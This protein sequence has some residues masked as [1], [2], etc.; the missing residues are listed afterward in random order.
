[1][2]NP[3]KISLKESADEQVLDICTDAI[4]QDYTINCTATVETA[5]PAGS[6]SEKALEGLN[7][8]ALSIAQRAPKRGWKVTGSQISSE[9]GRYHLRVT[10]TQK[11]DPLTIRKFVHQEV[12]TAL[13]EAVKDIT[14]DPS[15]CFFSDNTARIQAFDSDLS[16][17][18]NIYDAL[19]DPIKNA[20]WTIIEAHIDMAQ[21]DNG[22]G[23]LHALYITAVY[24]Q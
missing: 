12:Q 23:S 18:D 19:L 20:G 1:M 8:Q 4:W 6:T 21:E 9:T 10:M 17:L 22:P 2:S 3:Y 11:D 14:G 5:A 13:S 7:R 24:Q 15:P 16:A